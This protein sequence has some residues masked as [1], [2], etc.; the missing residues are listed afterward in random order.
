[1][2][3]RA[4]WFLTSV[5]ALGLLALLQGI[6]P[7]SSSSRI[8][9]YI[10]VIVIGSV[11]VVVLLRTCCLY[12][13][14]ANS[15]K[16]RAEQMA[17]LNLRTI[18]ALA[19]AIDAKDHIA[20]DHVQ[21][22]QIYAVELGKELALSPDELKGLQAAAV[23]HDI[24]KL[25]VPEHIISKPGRLTPEEFEKVKIHPV[26]GAEILERARFPYPVAPIVRAHHEKWDGTGYPEGLRGEAIP[27]AARILSAVDCLDALASDR[28]YRCAYPVDQAMALVE[29]ESGKSFDPAVVAVLKRRHADLEKKARVARV[30]RAS[31]QSPSV[32]LIAA[33]H[34]GPET[35]R[36]T[37]QPA[38]SET[39]FLTSIAAA[40]QEVQTLFEV[41]QHLGNSLS[42]P[43]TL[44]MLAMRLRPLIAFEAFAI[45]VE[46]D[47]KLVPEY[48][49]GEDRARLSSL[50]I[51]IGQG[52][53]GR[54]AEAREPIVNGNPSIEPGYLSDPAEPGKLNSALAVPL[55]D[56]SGVVGVLSL[57][58]TERDAF[59]RDQLRILQAITSKIA[60]VVRNSLMYQQATVTASTDY[61]TGLP[62]A[63][64][65]FLQ[66]DSELS[67]CRR[68][69]EP[70]T[71]LVCDLDDFK[72][73]N[74]EFGHLTG[75]VLLTR[76]AKALGEC[77][78][79]YDYVARM[80]GDE[81]VVILPG[82]NASTLPATL[83][84]IE[85]AVE[86]AGIEVCGSPTIHLSTGHAEFDRDGQ[87]VED[88]L[89]E[90]DRRMYANKRK[91]KPVSRE[92]R[93]MTAP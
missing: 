43:E 77:C 53:T 16:S 51:P 56:A 70:L 92:P 52:L 31:V 20:Q 50:E 68:N 61:L 59:A 87:D 3:V 64:S 32:A 83:R 6:T 49:I 9:L 81:F 69:H 60:V 40:R 89:A 10:G 5:V 13:E 85:K 93:V 14:R 25:A 55:E 73:V 82:M 27:L 17:A 54:V 23:L 36:N 47:G 75:N 46:R 79:E 71:V 57:Y 80:G 91:L 26:V 15:E 33:P 66:L 34:A 8:A 48:V 39:T 28:K 1:M 44:S 2:P 35:E 74:D 18:E 76:V 7:W 21:R 72:R 58:R 84:R 62:N 90:A 45:Y 86:Q 78:R 19:L 65:M 11:V 24:G 22:V 37:P 29:S 12:I 41:A 63:R 30:A 67:R 4:K 38:E 88:L 42:L